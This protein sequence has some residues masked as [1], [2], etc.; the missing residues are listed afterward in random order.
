MRVIRF[1]Y[2]ENIQQELLIY[3]EF[4][5]LVSSNPRPFN[6]EWNNNNMVE[7]IMNKYTDF[8]NNVF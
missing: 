7:F 5:P 1:T 4:K 2:E 3:R 6:I 8:A